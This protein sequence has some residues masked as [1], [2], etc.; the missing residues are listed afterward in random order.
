MRD[1]SPPSAGLTWTLVA[2]AGMKKK[3]TGSVDPTGS[4]SSLI[5]RVGIPVTFDRTAA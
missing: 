4:R 1:F 3:A 2:R 5:Q